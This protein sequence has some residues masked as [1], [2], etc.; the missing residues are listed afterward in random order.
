M[1][2]M[3]RFLKSTVLALCLFGTAAFA[4]SGRFSLDDV[5]EFDVLPGW[6]TETGTHM[7]ALHVRLAPG[8]KTYWRAPGEASIPPRF[9]WSGSRNLASAEFHWPTPEVF[10]QNGMRSVGYGGELVLPVELT[11]R[12]EGKRMLLRSEIQLGVCKDICVPV[13]TRIS[14]DLE[15]RGDRDPRILAALESRPETPHEAGLRAITCKVEPISDGLRLIA[16]IDIPR[17]GSHEVTVF[18]LPDHSIWVADARS[19]RTGNRLRAFTELVPPSN[20]PFLLDRS[21]VRITILG[22]ARA[23]DIV[24][25]TG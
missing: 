1:H 20:R 12:A 16:D 23:V 19:R 18:E 17:I 22:D 11:P 14:V 13:Q 24:G 8:W 9:D 4:D 5:A 25:C 15:G 21:S 2:G 3:S 10:F 7:A 6:R